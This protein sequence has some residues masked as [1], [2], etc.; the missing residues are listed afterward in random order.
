MN[1]ASVNR[2]ISSPTC[3]IHTTKQRHFALHLAYGTNQGLNEVN[4]SRL[5]LEH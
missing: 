3:S 1:D 5:R 4:E 2:I